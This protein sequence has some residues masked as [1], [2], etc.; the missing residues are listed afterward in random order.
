MGRVVALCPELTEEPWANGHDDNVNLLF[1]N[2]GYV[3]D[4]Y[5]PRLEHVVT[6]GN[7]IK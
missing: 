4:V 3:V 7:H 5:S 2:S 1:V 6:D